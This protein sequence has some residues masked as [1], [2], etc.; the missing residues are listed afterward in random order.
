MQDGLKTLKKHLKTAPKLPGVYRMLNAK[1]DVLYVG[2][3]KNLKNRLTSYTQTE[4]LS[5]RIR[6]MVFETRDLILVETPTE[7]EALL[8]EINLIQ[9]LKPRYN[10]KLQDDSTYPRILITHDDS[11]RL[12]YARGTTK[13]GDFFGPYPS[14]TAVHTTI[15]LL[16]RAFTLRTCPNSTF[17]H[18]TRPCLKYD[19]K[20]CS[21]P[22]VGK[23]SP[24]NY[25]DLVA[26]AKLFLQGKGSK[27]QQNIQQKMEEHAAREEYEEAAVLRNRLQALASVTQGHKSLT[28]AIEDGDVF[29]ITKEG[30]YACVQSFFYRGGQHVGNQTF[31]PKGVDEL[32]EGDIL[33]LFLAQYYVNRP[34][35]KHIFTSHP[36]A[37]ADLLKSLL[38]E[39]SNQKIEITCPQRGKK[40]AATAHAHTNAQAALKRRLAEG[41]G[42]AKQMAAFGEILNTEKTPQRVECFDISNISGKDAV[43]SMVVAGETEMLKSA[44]RKFTI[45]TKDTPDDY[46]MMREALSRRYKKADTD[47]WPL[48]DVILVDGG[49]GQLNVLVDV[50]KNLDLLNNTKTKLCAIAKG[51]ERDKGL[52]TI[53]LWGPEGTKEL[54]IPHNSPLIFVLQRIRDEAHRF[55]IGFHRQKRSQKITK[56]ILDDLP[57]IGPK[58][59]KALL[60]HFGS[61]ENVKGA[62]L[63]ELEKVSGISIAQAEKIYSYFR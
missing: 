58:R 38:E 27:L 22:C 5:H 19:I 8:L 16:E 24:K 62:S 56:S 20:R 55:A 15:D 52:E 48:P 3:A 9:S 18:R 54:P 21:A 1:G 39:Q 25:A 2:K 26:Q 34:A 45:K 33:R 40:H 29:G 51:E 59:K 31:F 28:N 32:N 14:A 57:G 35:P 13:K 63:K 61:L 37:E 30:A 7:A 42:W 44:Y 4:N 41:K 36:V 60:L 12:M 53:F 47:E 17:K 46:G 11:P 23:V 43:A 49:K 10:I 6:K 50:F